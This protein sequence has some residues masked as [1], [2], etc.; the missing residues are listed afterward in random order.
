ERPHDEFTRSQDRS[1]V[2][3]PEELG[4][5]IRTRLFDE[6]PV[7]SPAGAQD[8]EDKTGLEPSWSGCPANIGRI[9]GCHIAIELAHDAGF[10]GIAVDVTGDRQ[11]VA[12]SIHQDGLV[13]APEQRTI[14]P[15]LPVV[16]LSEQTVEVPHGSAEVTFRG[17]Q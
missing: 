12:V 9:T 15:Q 11:E 7:F 10:Q 14:P 17:T 13:A 8:V 6:L 3:L 2:A 4:Y 16:V 5:L 1:L